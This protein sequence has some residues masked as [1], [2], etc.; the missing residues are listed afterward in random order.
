VLKTRQELE[1]ELEESA[2]RTRKVREAAEALR[3]AG[4]L[5]EPSEAQR[6]VSIVSPTLSPVREVKR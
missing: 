2:K 3:G 6:P 1:R 4:E 5:A